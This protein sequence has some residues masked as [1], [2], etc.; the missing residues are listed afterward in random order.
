MT[1]D[2][3]PNTRALERRHAQSRRIR[4]SALSMANANEQ[5]DAD[6]HLTT[7]TTTT[8]TAKDP[9]VP[10]SQYRSPVLEQS[11]L[12]D[13]G[14]EH[15]LWE[16]IQLEAKLVLQT[17]PEVGTQIYQFV[18]SQPSLLDALSSVIAQELE[19]E[20]IPA[21]Q[22]VN[23]MCE[24]LSP[25]PEDL[26]ALEQDIIAAATRSP[27]I[28]SALTS[29]LH[30]TGLHALVAFRVGHRLWN[31]QRKGLAYYLQ[32]T[33]SRRYSAD[34]HPACTMGVGIYLKAGAGG[35]VIGETAKIGNNVSILQGVTLGG[36]GKERG[37]RH[38]K[39]GDGVILGNDASVLGNI[40]V[41]DGA[42]VTAKSI[43]TKPV[44]PLAVMT[45]VPAKVMRYRSIK[46]DEDAELEFNTD[47]SEHL[48]VK[49][50]DTWRK[51][52]C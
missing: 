26:L 6:D 2:A 40:P 5:E 7:T 3:I 52:Y 45:G 35:I 36:T 16:Q 24:M 27:S 17:E 28:D 44:K 34:L 38:P 41:G 1:T 18:L 48:A 46:T 19:T 13:D 39:V 23:L 43:V 21:T 49:Y 15:S 11:G 14:Q 31:A 51:L 8:T 37:D 9:F 29:M 50:L 22:L 20:L 12:F 10:L 30:N 42:V 25:H 4:I 33:V 32:S 47:L